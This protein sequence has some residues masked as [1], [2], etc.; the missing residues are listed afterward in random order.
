MQESEDEQRARLAYEA[1]LRALDQQRR[2]LEEIR[3]RTGVLLAAASICAS[4]LGSK[5]LERHASV[6]VIVL[7]LTA[8]VM[9]L[10]LGILVLTVRERLVFSVSGSELHNRLLVVRT[11]ADQH[12]YL[13]EWLTAAWNRNEPSI[14]SIN[15]RLRAMAGAL[16]I[17]MVL[18]SLA[19]GV[20]VSSTP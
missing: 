3:S 10:L 14:R 13:A 7:A 5:A 15:A 1:S 12:R 16:A 17:Q 4:F 11:R 2:S 19:L 9:T 20:T 18:W 8:L 6:I